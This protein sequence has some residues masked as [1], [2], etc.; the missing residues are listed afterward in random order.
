METDHG[1]S[2]LS[3]RGCAVLFRGP[4]HNRCS[5]CGESGSVPMLRI[6][7]YHLPGHGVDASPDCINCSKKFESVNLL[8]TNNC[9]KSDVSLYD[10]DGILSIIN[11][12]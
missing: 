10:V 7:R 5:G 2:F 6:A 3:F 12:S 8:I 9:N 4:N 11:P 1:G